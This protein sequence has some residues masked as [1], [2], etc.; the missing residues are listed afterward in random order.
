[1]AEYR[2]RRMRREEMDLAIEWAA[3]EGWNPGLND[4]GLFFDTDPQ[5]FFIGELDGE[6][7]ASLS[8]VA[9]GAGF[10]FM[11]LYI[12]RPQFRG[13]G[14]GLQLWHQVMSYLGARNIGLDG[15]VEQQPNYMKS[16]FTLAH[17][18][19]RYEGVGPAPRNPQA[20]PS[21]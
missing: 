17:R 18:N 6:P 3:A 7:V 21:R 9:Y 10:G 20:P 13:R 16:G 12:V 1:M 14:F 8:G 2:V 19:V 4:A 15:V 11:G 5:G